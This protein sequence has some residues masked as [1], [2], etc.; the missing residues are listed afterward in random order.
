MLCAD[1]FD[2]ETGKHKAPELSRRAI[3]DKFSDVVGKL[4]EVSTI[5]TFPADDLLLAP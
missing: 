1:G 5:H 4:D 3:L 2:N